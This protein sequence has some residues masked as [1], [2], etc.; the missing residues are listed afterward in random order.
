MAIK[1]ETPVY[2]VLAPS[3]VGQ[4]GPDAVPEKMKAAF[5]RLG[6][7]DVYEAAIGADLCVIEEAS[8]FLNEVPSKLERSSYIGCCIFGI[9]V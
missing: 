7:A 6:F 2:V 9:I 3:F 8:D 5:K 4:F 1:S